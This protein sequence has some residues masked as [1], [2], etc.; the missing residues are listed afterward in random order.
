MAQPDSGDIGAVLQGVGAIAQAMAIFAA[1]WLASNTFQNWRKQKLSERRIEQ[2]ERILTA[3][4]HAR[5]ALNFVRNPWGD[6]SESKIAEDYLKSKDFWVNTPEG[7]RQELIEKQSGYNRL[8]KTEE[9]RK[10]LSQCLPMA[11][12]LFNDTVEDAIRI[13]GL[14]FNKVEHA[15]RFAHLNSD[16]E[17]SARRNHDDRYRFGSD[18]TMDNTIAKQIEVLERELFPIL[19]LDK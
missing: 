3:A 1:A 18:N 17:E 4:Y 8:N 6:A 2:A 5:D 11:R 10:A 9:D 15:I 13:L 14:Q 19:R 7:K 12:A 16:N